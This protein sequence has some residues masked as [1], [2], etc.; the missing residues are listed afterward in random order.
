MY[1]DQ[2]SGQRWTHVRVVKNT[3]PGPFSKILPNRFWG[4]KKGL[5]VEARTF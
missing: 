1:H 4:K 3:W 2:L 5:F